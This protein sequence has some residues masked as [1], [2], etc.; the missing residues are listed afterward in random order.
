LRCALLSGGLLASAC[1]HREHGGEHAHP[2]HH[3]VHHGPAQHRFED[4][5]AWAKRFD[6]PARDA[7]QR[8]DEVV[9]ALALAPDATVADVG[10][11]TG[12][13]TV[14]LARAVPRGR[15]YGVDIEPD[16]AR[17]LGERARRE[18]LGN[19]VPVLAEA[20]ALTLPAP[21]D[22]VLLV[23]TYHHIEDRVPYFQGLRSHLAPGGRLAIIDFR[24]GA[25]LGPPEA[26]RIP[27]EQVRQ[28][29][30]AAGWRFTGEHGFL[31][32]QYF[33][34]FVPAGR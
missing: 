5:E 29:L 8:P 1:A 20:G 30:E 32:H 7:W 3:G 18:G 27:P 25:P 34:L 10:S 4:A 2:E 24:R 33:L 11:G 26:H 31:P 13:F 9:A 14:R 23:D 21:V 6:D 22:L 12:Y 28:E 19:V 17:Y 16:M 15:V